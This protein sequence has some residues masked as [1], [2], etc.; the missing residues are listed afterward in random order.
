MHRIDNANPFNFVDDDLRVEGTVYVNQGSRTPGVA[1]RLPTTAGA[2]GQVPTLNSD[3]TM[4]WATPNA[5][6]SNKIT[7][8]DGTDK[9]TSVAA[10][11]SDNV[12]ITCD[13][14]LA[15]KFLPDMLTLYGQVGQP[16]LRLN[17]LDNLAYVGVKAPGA[18]ATSWDL[19]L[20]A[21]APAR[22]GQA[23]TATPGGVSSWADAALAGGNS[24]GAA[25]TLG[26]NDAFG[27][28]LRTNSRDVFMIDG[29]GNITGTGS[30]WTQNSIP[31]TF[32]VAGSTKTNYTTSA[33]TSFN[34]P[35]GLDTMRVQLWG[36]GGGASGGSGA[37]TEVTLMATPG[38]QYW[39]ITGAGGAVTSG[40]NAGGTNAS[41]GGG[42]GWNTGKCGG[43]GQYSAL[44]RYIADTSRYVLI[45]AAGG[46]GGGQDIGFNGGGGN[47][48][49]GGNTTPGSGGIG[50]SSSDAGSTPGEDY[51][52]D[53]TTAGHTSL[54]FGGYGGSAQ[55][56]NR[57]GGG[58]GYGGGGA[59]SSGSSG[60][61]SYIP[62]V[63][64]TILSSSGVNG[65][66]GV[67]EGVTV[68]NNSDA[69]Y[70]D[71]YGKGGALSGAGGGGLA[72]VTLT[73]DQNYFG[74]P[75]DIAVTDGNQLKLFKEDNTASVKVRAA[76]AT[77][78]YTLTLPPAAGTAGQVLGTTGG[79]ALDWVDLR[80]T[81]VTV[82][83][84]F[85][86]PMVEDKFVTV[87]SGTGGV[88]LPSLA[89]VEITVRNATGGNIR[90]LP[91]PFGKIDG[92]LTE[93]TI[94]NDTSAT[95]V[96]T[97]IGTWYRF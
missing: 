84:T 43:G 36:A 6:I 54:A 74:V 15:A 50:G 67:A 27:L 63:T 19:Q 94:A 59:G 45:A 92:T 51:A 18:G 81:L 53:A 52:P 83:A 24:L 49:S 8:V 46:G 77:T 69:N 97:T 95:F 93:H 30:R 96:S 55:M 88:S 75:V 34:I 64:G 2:S 31:L 17:Q 80:S 65:L 7:N 85:G 10:G 73:T 71:G 25:L 3:G 12:D 72:V 78:D 62:P 28:N 90:V 47:T 89:N 61:G 22:T 11:T 60:G 70:I 44:V 86:Y 87:M 56:A 41:G 40:G 48:T 4:S 39:L 37:Y 26:T 57:A 23:L 32:S 76:A 21:A 68:P 91:N 5:G 20:P 42:N 58:G 33:V 82:E 29:L 38:T 13:G 66:T 16:S 14:L 9:V 1:F 79:G 35:A